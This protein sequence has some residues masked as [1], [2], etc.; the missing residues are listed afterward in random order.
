MVGSH[1]LP[2]MAKCTTMRLG[3]NQE[4]I[5]SSSFHTLDLRHQQYRPTSGTRGE[6]QSES[7]YKA[8]PLAQIGCSVADSQPLSHPNHKTDV[9]AWE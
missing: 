2:S 9:D 3:R 7:V 1:K 4:A 6:I 5:R 8:S